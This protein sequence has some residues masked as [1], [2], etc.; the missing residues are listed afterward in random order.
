[1]HMKLGAIAAL[2]AGLAIAVFVLL[3]IGI[4]PVLNAIAR[5]GW[6]GFALVV[7]CGFVVI[8]L[9]GTA[10]YALLS[11]RVRWPIFVAARQLRDSASELLPFTQLGGMVIGA[12][13]VVIGG[14]AAPRAFASV[15]VDVTMEFMAQIAFVLLG[16]MLGIA[17]LRASAT[18]APYAYGLILGTA[19]LVPGVIAFVVLQRRGSFLAEKLAGR[20]LPAAVS[21]T[22][23]FAGA[24]NGLYD[25]PSRLAISSTMHLLSW[26]ASGVWLWV[27]MRLIGAEVDVFS[28]IAIESLLGAL[29]GVTFFIPSS[30]GVQEA[31]YAALA[32]V[33]GM[34]PEIGL[35]VSLLKRAR[36][37]VV[38]VPV[39]LIWQVLEGK[40]AFTQQNGEPS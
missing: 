5:V 8:A 17:Q 4:A 10:W 39:L 29:R 19:L 14:L 32:S 1:M 22:E 26:I 40:R 2:L 9:L 34:G 16:L 21:H 30:V 20:F 35:A 24:L 3:H 11:D 12:R 27:V 38:G 33:F 13:A 37:I 25:R 28:A 7:L 6:G 31:G 15:M 36:D 18:L 23:A